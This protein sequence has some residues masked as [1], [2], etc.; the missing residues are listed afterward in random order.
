MQII[1][2]TNQDTLITLNIKMINNKI[3]KIKVNKSECV[4]NLKIM[5]QDVFILFNN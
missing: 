2:S 3:Y 1:E 5:I 4:N